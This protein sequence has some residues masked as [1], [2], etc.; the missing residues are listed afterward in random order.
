M[1]VCGES[2]CVRACSYVSYCMRARDDAGCTLFR[3]SRCTS[4]PLPVFI[5]VPVCSGVPTPLRPFIQKKSEGENRRWRMW[6]RRVQRGFS[7]QKGGE[8]QPREHTFERKKKDI[9]LLCW[10]TMKSVNF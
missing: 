8:K 2:V 1:G 7:P 5:I 9:F 4:A 6:K 3:G 10:V